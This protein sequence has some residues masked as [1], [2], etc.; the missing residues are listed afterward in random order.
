MGF[1]FSHDRNPRQAYLACRKDVV[2]MKKIIPSFFVLLM[3]LIFSGCPGY[4]MSDVMRMCDD[5]R[6]FPSYAACIRHTYDSKGNSP[7]AGSVRAFYALLDE[8]AEGYNQG[9]Q[10]PAQAKANVYRA[11][12]GTIDADNS[13]GQICTVVGNMVVCR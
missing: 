3:P 9:R 11:W 13:R 6:S 4:L 7:N 2:F 5:G 8:I 12:Q 10:S 1:R